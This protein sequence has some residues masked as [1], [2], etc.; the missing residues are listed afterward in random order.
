MAILTPFL[1]KQVL[2]AGTP[3][4][5]YSCPV[6]KSHAIVDVH[7]LKTSTAG[8]SLI[9]IGLTTKTDPAQV[10]ST[11]YFI[12]DIE[13]IGNIN[14]AELNKVIIGS[15]EKLYVKVSSGPDVNVR[16]TGIEENNP[17]V[18]DAGRLA[19]TSV[20]GTSRATIYVNNAPSISYTSASITVYNSSNTNSADVK[21]WVTDASVPDAVDRVLD[22]VLP[23]QD[24]II[25]ENLTILPN[26]KI[27]VQ[28]SQPNT[29]W[30]VNGIAIASA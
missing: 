7:F 24:T 5:V 13:L 11:D 18:I 23:K 30:F 22:V 1:T 3:L 19:A 16:I 10:D 17:N 9:M 29:E 26:E 20:A 25:L 12:D 28:S 8:D 4:E 15:G 2:T 14:S 6:G 21:M 27:F